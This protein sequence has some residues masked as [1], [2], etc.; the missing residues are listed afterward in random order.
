MDVRISNYGLRHGLSRNS[1]DTAIAMLSISDLLKNS[2]VVNELDGSSDRKTYMSY[3]LLSYCKIYNDEFIVRTIIEKQSNEIYSFDL[4]RLSAVKDKKIDN[5]NSTLKRGAAVEKKETSPYP[6]GYPKI[7]ISDLLNKVKYLNL[8]N[9]VF[10]KDVAEKL[11]IARHE[12]TLSKDLRYSVKD[13]KG[14]YNYSKGQIAKYV[15]SHS[16]EK[17]YSREDVYRRG[18]LNQTQSDGDKRV[19][20]R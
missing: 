3:I 17:V 15:A 12:G 19:N 1:E 4:F 5:P 13:G 7:S 16:K 14:D 9:E 6:S 11:N 2:I 10:S 18:G 8:A 20:C